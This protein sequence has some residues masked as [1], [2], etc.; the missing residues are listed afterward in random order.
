MTDEEL[1]IPRMGRRILDVDGGNLGQTEEL[2]SW[3]RLRQFRHGYPSSHWEELISGL[4][5]GS[6]VR[7][8]TL[9]FLSLQFLHPDRDF[10][11]VL[12]FLTDW[13]SDPLPVTKMVPGLEDF[14]RVKHPKCGFGELSMYSS[15]GEACLWLLI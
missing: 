15:E 14:S 1:V 6:A 2:H 12:R 5:V 7:G 8:H 9:I 3:F 13:P 11:W 10:V 4:V